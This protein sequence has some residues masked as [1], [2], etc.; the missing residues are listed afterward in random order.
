[1]Q[2][3]IHLTFGVLL[4]ITLISLGSDASPSRT[5]RSPVTHGKDAQITEFPFFVSL[6][7]GLGYQLCGGA[8]ISRHFV[9]TAAHCFKLSNNTDEYVIRAGT[10]QKGYGG[11]EHYII[12]LDKHPNY[13]TDRTNT[14]Y[15]DIA[16]VGVKEPFKFDKYREHNIPMFRAGDEVIPGT[17]A[18]IIG[19]GETENGPTDN[20]KSAVIKITEKSECMK[21]WFKI[22]SIPIPKSVICAGVG[23][24]RRD[25]CNHDSGSP[26][27]VDGRL[28]GIT[29]FGSICGTPGTPG[30]Y[31][32]VSQF[33]K[34]VVQTIKFRMRFR[35][36]WADSEF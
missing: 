12:S 13:R 22:D 20:L 5:K 11:T 4:I 3:S 32:E 9:V 34:W 19:I 7:L 8:I 17:E 16:V 31:T 30:L 25:A 24:D 23:K 21:A 33:Q 26:L 29:S 36:D 18:I 1:M 14:P 28:A 2:R 6:E 35:M 10:D 15:N 27:I